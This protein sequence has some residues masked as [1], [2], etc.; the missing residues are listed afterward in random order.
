MS[1]D[2]ARLALVILVFLTLLLGVL[3]LR[4]EAAK[5]RQKRTRKYPAYVDGLHLLLEGKVEEA[6]QALRAAAEDGPYVMEARLRLG[7]LLRKRG[8]WEQALRI[9]NSLRVLPALPEEMIRHLAMAVAQDYRAGDKPE[10]AVQ[11][12]QDALAIT[13]KDPELLEALLLA[14]EEAGKW[15]D[16]I[17]V[18]RRLERAT[19]GS[20]KQQIALYY[21]AWA[22]T[23]LSE[24]QDRKARSE[25]KKALAE[26]HACGAA[27]LV[28]GDLALEGGDV[29]RAVNEWV[30][31]AEDSPELSRLA[32]LRIE[33]ALYDAGNY[34]R[35]PHVYGKLLESR[36]D[37]ISALLRLAN[38]AERK[39]A[40]EE[41]I[42]QAE[43]A[44]EANPSAIMPRASLAAYLSDL[45]RSTDASRECREI[46][47]ICEE[48]WLRFICPFCGNE[49]REFL[50]RCPACRRVGLF[51]T[52]SV[53]DQETS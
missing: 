44:V 6:A 3:F 5:R 14:L 33:K 1:L 42:E 16:A 35:I 21:V 36:P 7:A 18:A 17:A 34:G 24:G 31:M 20:L 11:P 40:L 29:D 15:E 4:R 37:D 28:A 26:D 2:G 25:L 38:Y 22:Q 19:E 10:L 23:S 47:R 13:S 51:L 45:E 46:L 48:Q 12:L 8:S 53:C 27:R 30:K 9:H 41:A 50:W 49:E 32:F 39:G 43:L 52:D